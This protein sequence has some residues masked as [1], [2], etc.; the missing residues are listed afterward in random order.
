[1]DNMVDA[2]TLDFYGTVVHE[3]DLVISG[4][5]DRVAS[6]VAH[7]VD[8][9]GIATR[10][11]NCFT[12]ECADSFGRQFR[13]QRAIARSSLVKVLDDVAS[14]LD[15][16][17]L[18]TAQFDFWRRPP[19]FD[20]AKEF[21]ARIDMPVCIVSNINRSDLEAAMAHHEL[22]FDHVVTSEDARSY[23][24][25]PEPFRHAL[26]RLGVAGSAALHI[27]DS[28][29]SDIA[30]AAA[31]G[32]AAA[33]VNRAGRRHPPHARLWAEISNL[34]ELADLLEAAGSD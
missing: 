5:C 8:T 21:L 25:R 22:A 9:T 23:K 28:L 26:D 7:M 12:Q 32:I 31:M 17:E 19:L 13:T 2:I 20:E 33:L 24:P 10:W 14:P 27:G 3:D 4:I 18:L 6:S 1:M 16:D 15:P 29:S 11:S 30:G 34:G